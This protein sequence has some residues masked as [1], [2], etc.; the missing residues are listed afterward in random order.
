MKS[1]RDNLLP[2]LNKDHEEQLG[3]GELLE[4]GLIG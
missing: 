2:E 4:G 3:E 1:E